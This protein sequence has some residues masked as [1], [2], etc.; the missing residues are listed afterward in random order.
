[1]FLQKK[2]QVTIY[3]KKDLKGDAL[4]AAFNKWDTKLTLTKIPFEAVDVIKTSS[5]TAKE[6]E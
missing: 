6:L 4:K 3:G 1:M 5:I 2:I